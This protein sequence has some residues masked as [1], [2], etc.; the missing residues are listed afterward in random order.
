MQTQIFKLINKIAKCKYLT[1]SQ[2]LKIVIML[3]KIAKVVA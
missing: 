2:R 1:V 3:R